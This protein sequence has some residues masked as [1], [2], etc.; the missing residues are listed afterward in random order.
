[1]KIYR[2]VT[3]AEL[4]E[5]TSQ[6]WALERVLTSSR[7]SREQL[8]DQAPPPPNS[9]YGTPTIV[10]TREEA[11]VVREPVYLVWRESEVVDHEAAIHDRYITDQNNLREQIAGLTL[12]LGSNDRDLRELRQQLE[13]LKPRADA[14][15][16]SDRRVRR[17]EASLAK[18]KEAIGARAYDEI[19]K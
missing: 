12:T 5:Y 16:E 3:G 19:L 11:L 1:V 14:A 18:I 10:S 7:V 8:A 6:G 4:E 17:L 13:R 2:Q 15:D 9:P